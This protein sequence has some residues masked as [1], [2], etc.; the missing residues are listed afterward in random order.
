MEGPESTET[1]DITVLCGVVESINPPT[2]G[3]A[4]PSIAYKFVLFIQYIYIY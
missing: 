4:T 1:S 2:L 3:L